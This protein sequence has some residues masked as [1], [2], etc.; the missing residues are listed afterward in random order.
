M[1]LISLET[2][3]YIHILSITKSCTMHQINQTSATW[4]KLKIGCSQDL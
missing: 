1:W 2:I 3:K 4:V